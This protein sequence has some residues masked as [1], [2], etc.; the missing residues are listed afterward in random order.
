MSNHVMLSPF[1]D[2]DSLGLLWEDLKVLPELNPPKEMPKGNVGTPLSVFM[3]LI[4][5][6]KLPT[7][8]IKKL[9]L[10]FPKSRS[11]HRYGAVRLDYGDHGNKEGSKEYNERDDLGFRRKRG[12]QKGNRSETDDQDASDDAI[13][14]VSV[15]VCVC[16]CVCV[17]ACV[18]ACVCVCVCACV[19][20]RV[21]VCVCVRACVR[22]SVCV[23]ACMRPLGSAYTH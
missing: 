3:S 15:C 14:S 2:K 22:V 9:R 11:A 16:V 5:S 12:R 13:T 1:P 23:R 20:V 18:R 7:H 8:V 6:C 19:C 21:C 4:R 17:R 10:E